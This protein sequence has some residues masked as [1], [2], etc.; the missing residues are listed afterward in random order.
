MHGKT[1]K[2]SESTFPL[3]IGIEKRQFHVTIVS[4]TLL[5]NICFKITYSMYVP[6]AGIAQSVYRLATGWTVRGSNPS[7]RVI[8]SAPIPTGPGAHPAS[9]T[10]DT[11]SFQETKRPGRGLDHPPPSTAEVKERVE[12]YL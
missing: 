12:L 7:G 5:E 10:M 8:F 1:V 11:G 9:Y 2:L 6:R 4:F 3:H